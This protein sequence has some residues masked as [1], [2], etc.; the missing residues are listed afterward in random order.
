MVQWHPTI[1]SKIALVPQRTMASYRFDKLGAAYEEG[2]FVVMFMA[3]TA[4]GGNNC[5]DTAMPYFKKW[6][7][8]VEKKD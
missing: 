7:E 1:L 4:K 8:L 6:Q 2:D 3:C 5:E